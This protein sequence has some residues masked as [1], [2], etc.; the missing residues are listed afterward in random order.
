MSNPIVLSQ[1]L[2]RE[3]DKRWDEF[4]ASPAY[5]DAEGYI[6][7][8]LA[9]FLRRAFAVSDF[10]LKNCT[11]NPEMTAALFESGD[12]F[13]GY[14]GEAYARSLAILLEDVEDEA[15]LSRI[16][17]LFRRREMT[18]IAFRD[19]SGLADLWETMAD[20]SSL[21]E[22]C[23][24]AA[25]SCLYDRH[26]VALGTPMDG[27]GHAQKLVVFGMGKLGARELNFSSDIDLIFAYPESG[28][29]RGGPRIVT[30]EEFFIRLS[31][32]LIHVLG[33]NTADGMVF[34]VDMN[35]R[36]YGESGPL[37]MGFDAMET[38]Y[39]EQGREW[40][41]YAWIKARPLAGDF[42]AGDRLAAALRPFIY[43][44]YLDFGVFESLR[45][46]KQM[47]A[48]EVKRKGMA[49]NIKLGPGGIREVEFFGQIF[50]LIR[51]G[52]VP[53]L[54]ER[55]I[56]TVLSLLVQE[57]CIAPETC[58]T[59]QEAYIF[60][61]RVEHRLQAVNDAQTHVL[62]K[63]EPGRARLAAAMGFDGWASFYDCLD[64]YRAAV[65]GHFNSLLKMEESAPEK[66]AAAE[67]LAEIWDR[68]RD[69]ADIR[70][71]LQS[72][73]YDDPEAAFRC[74]KSFRDELGD[75]VLSR[76]GRDRITRLMPLVIAGAGRTDDS[77]I[78]LERTIDLIRAIRRRT[79]YVALLLE[80]PHALDHLIRLADTSAWI[81]RLLARQ[82]VLMDELLDART[83]Y[84]PPERSEL[85][86]S[87]ARNQAKSD[88]D[89]LEGHMDALRL[90]RQINTLKV[91]AADITNAIP[92]MRVSDHLS[93]IAETV[94]RRVVEMSAV[95]LFERHG[96]PPCDPPLLP[97]ERGFAVIAYGKLGGLELG[98][99]SDLDLVFLHSGVGGLSD[100][101]Q[102]VDTTT[103]YSR[104]GQRVLHMLSTHTAAGRL[105]E[106]DMR[107][108][109][110]GAAGILVSSVSGFREYQLN[111]AWTWEKQALVRAR[112]IVGDPRLMDRFQEIRRE[113]LAQP[114]NREALRA[115]IRDMR[116]R[117]RRDFP[118]PEPGQFD[119]KQGVGG[120]VDIEFLVQY[121]VL[122]ESHR[123]PE[124][125]RWTDNV[126][127][128][129]SLA[130]ARIIDEITAYFLRK[131]YL[132][133][134]SMGHKLSLREKPARV[135]DDRFI[136]LRERVT[137][138]WRRYVGTDSTS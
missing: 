61:R 50:Q 137:A 82:P 69:D 17:R 115:E 108:R 77:C 105:Y 63:D 103:F 56:Y 29:T 39:Q 76:E 118:A 101:R 48:L 57:G 70:S 60:L 24:A 16:L 104:L 8:E 123:R 31:R 99:D 49:D 71:I 117:M 133:Y 88:P 32:R 116:A 138:V 41:R 35:L 83:L 84:L 51:G 52:V 131:A 113:I 10:M 20:L 25:L 6:T 37:A 86:A 42:A 92:L 33:A 78:A 130:D 90:F 47:I 4:R 135:S 28:E 87:L 55:R 27:E 54:Q 14:D 44:R 45:E 93:D 3:A 36:P 95:H 100:G 129:R 73:G 132:T 7:S 66:D 119:L 43:R 59:L 75:Q 127:L 68:P 109:P 5:A 53:A 67:P 26:C 124:I 126:R 65:H 21:A 121:L 18:R 15:G 23:I 85:E 1:E 72:A 107:L 34:R 122:L 112:P 30:N 111:E 2:A 13:R 98:Y 96:T 102:P 19:L 11:R 12:L 94:L 128:I 114:R 110:S 91:A 89:D 9:E 64:A 46:M 136:E 74:I 22:G 120:M 106:V 38:Y 40:E 97:G 80:N 62:P 125:L 79:S 134:R 81:M 58:R